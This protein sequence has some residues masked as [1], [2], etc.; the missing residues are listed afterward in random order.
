[1]SDARGRAL[2]NALAAYLQQWWRHAESAGSGRN[3]TDILGTPGVA[4]EVKTAREFKRDF[5]P[6]AWVKQAREH[7]GECDCTQ[8]KPCTHAD[9]PVVVYFP[10]GI[11]AE[12]CANTLAIMPVHVLMRLL[13]EAGYTPLRWERE[14][15][16]EVT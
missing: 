1:M 8:L 2:P 3:G 16:K 7:A 5:K 6:T 15:E 10:S 12:N 11:G 13:E 9:V 14:T 4:W